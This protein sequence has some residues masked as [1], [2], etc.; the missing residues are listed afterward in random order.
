MKLIKSFYLSPLFFFLVTA[1]IFLFVISYFISPLLILTKL[2]LITLIVFLIFDVLIL[3]ANRNGAYAYRE[4]PNRLSNG[5]ENEIKIFITNNYS[6]RI[7][8]TIIDELPFDLQ[9]RDNSFSI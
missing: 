7:K 4:S 5:D 1:I 2:I 9:I 3:Y 6:F 8:T